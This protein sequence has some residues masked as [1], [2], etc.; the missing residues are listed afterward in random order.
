MSDGLNQIV[1]TQPIVIPPV[2]IEPVATGE[3]KMEG[4]IDQPPDP[5]TLQVEIDR[6][7]DVKE[8]AEEDARYWRKQKVEARAEYFKGRQEPP[9]PPPAE[10]RGDLGIGPEP[11]QEAF[12]DY[13]KYLDAK[14]SYEVNKA[15]MTWDREEVKKKADSERQ[16]KIE[17]LREKINVGYQ[18]YQDFE[19][20]AMAPEVPITPA[21][22]E[23]LSDCENPH[24]IAYYLGKN[25]SEA[26]RISRLNPIQVA[27]E[28]AKIEVEIAKAINQ[29][30]VVPKIPSAPPP[31]RPVGSGHSIGK[32]PDQM[33]QKEYE[34][35]ASQNPRLRRF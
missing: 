5:A 12:D 8:K 14:I 3:V 1:E 7:K 29:P 23:I 22:M 17:N 6:L 35:W 25:R 19:E 28:I 13:Q 20:V 11:K 10:T 34:E 21:V 32:K 9:P 2:S 26:I 15:K 16:N 24:R 31:I 30:P 18:E 4:K 27:R 33:T